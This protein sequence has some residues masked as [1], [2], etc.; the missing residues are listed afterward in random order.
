MYLIVIQ[1]SYTIQYS[2][3]LFAKILLFVQLG[4]VKNKDIS[5]WF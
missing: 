3:A 1:F 5:E 4:F 2:K